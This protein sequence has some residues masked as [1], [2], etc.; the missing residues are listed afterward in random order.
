MAVMAQITT[1]SRGW[2]K[3]GI[4][5]S[6]DIAKRGKS[7]RWKS[8]ILVMKRMPKVGSR[9]FCST[10]LRNCGSKSNVQSTPKP[11]LRVSH[12]LHLSCNPAYDEFFRLPWICS[13]FTV[14]GKCQIVVFEIRESIS[15]S[16]GQHD[17]PNETVTTAKVT[18]VT[19][20]NSR[21]F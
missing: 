11:N 18:P 21:G 15:R 17:A 8:L 6:D 20:V 1:T 5:A 19:H 9:F 13:N 4:N 14:N 12:D 10:T 2:C 3:C 16:P 7:R